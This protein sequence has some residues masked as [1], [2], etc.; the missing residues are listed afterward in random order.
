MGGSGEKERSF[1]SH[2]VGSLKDQPIGWIGE[3]RRSRADT[4]RK[5]FDGQY[6]AS[7]LFFYPLVLLFASLAPLFKAVGAS[8]PPYAGT[9][10]RQVDTF[11]KNVS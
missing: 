2:D 4:E 11:P 8:S 7:A 5:G 10:T 9:S 6:W 3:T 1:R